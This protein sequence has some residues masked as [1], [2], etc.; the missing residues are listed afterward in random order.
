MKLLILKETSCFMGGGGGGGFCLYPYMTHQ[1]G[2]TK[3]FHFELR[4]IC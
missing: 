3:C 1:I 4:K 2:P